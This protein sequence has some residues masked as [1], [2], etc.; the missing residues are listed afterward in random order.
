[1]GDVRIGVAASDPHG[2]IATPVETVAAGRRDVARILELVTE[3]EA[4]E[5]VVGLPRSL[6]GREGAAAAKAR[7][8]AGRLV[9]ALGPAV[10]VRLVDERLTTVTA[11]RGLQ[12]SGVKA[13]KARG[14]VDQAA[15][16]VILQNALDTERASGRPAGSAMPPAVPVS[17]PERPSA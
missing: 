2:L 10:G 9:A 16:I 15:A 14:V 4:I 3:Y 7:V 12:A 17:D 5:V 8:F 11:T 1:V 13:K 6:S